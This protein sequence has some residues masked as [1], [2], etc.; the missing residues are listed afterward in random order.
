MIANYHTHTWRCRHAVGTEE[1]YV[2]SAVYRGLRILG[3][4]DHTPY[5]FPAWYDSGY[6]MELSQLAGYA[7]VVQSLKDKYAGQ[8]QIHLGLEAEYYPQY[9][10]DLLAKLRDQGIEYLLLGQHF[11]GNEIGESYCGR[12]TSEEETLERYCDQ[13]VQAMQTGLFTYL[14]HP[15]LMRYVGPGSVYEHHMR[16][17]CRE[18]K[19]CGV[20]LEINLLGLRE[21]RHY[22]DRR[23]WALAAEEG[24]ACILGCDA[25]NPHGLTA[26]GG[27][28]E[29]LRM[30]RD[31]GL[32]LLDT[33][34]LRPLF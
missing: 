17:L 2:Q 31:L 19:S 33:V 13:T 8:I 32:T 4:S 34:P 27:E 9:F 6:R 7:Q 5:S 22:P 18:A 10:P 1:E 3:F 29:A 30:V 20:P 28:R 15:D 12:P 25:H 24:C 16:R 14:A 26:P 21:G 23:F 11:L